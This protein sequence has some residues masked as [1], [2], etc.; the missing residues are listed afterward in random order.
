M[1]LCE[2]PSVQEPLEGKFQV[3]KDHIA[4]DD[5]GNATDVKKA[6]ELRYFRPDVVSLVVRPGFG[7]N[8]VIAVPVY[9]RFT[10]SAPT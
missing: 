9:R 6:T 8:E 3:L 2:V 10:Q 1:F 5:N 7:V 4:V